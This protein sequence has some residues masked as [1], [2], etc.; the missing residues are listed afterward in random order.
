MSKYFAIH[1]GKLRVD[2]HRTEQES[3]TQY[4]EVGL[5]DVRASDCIRISYDFARDGWVIAQAAYCAKTMPGVVLGPFDWKEVAFVESWAREADP[6]RVRIEDGSVTYCASAETGAVAFSDALPGN[7]D[8][9]VSP[10]S[11]PFTTKKLVGFERI[12]CG[13]DPATPGTENTAL[14]FFN[15]NVVQK[16]E[17]KTVQHLGFT[18]SREDF[19][20]LLA[21]FGHSSCTCNGSLSSGC[22]LCTKD[23]FQRWYGERIN[24]K[25]AGALSR[26]K[27]IHETLACQPQRIID[28]IQRIAC[29][30]FTREEYDQI[31]RVV[32]QGTLLPPGYLRP[33]AGITAAQ[34]ETPVASAQEQ[35]EQE[36]Q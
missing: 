15:P 6:T 22:P 8:I 3:N 25:H 20:A 32:A 18:V 27:R 35:D 5:M 19:D 21:E 12:I 4:I 29:P 33:D 2:L 17:V 11:T 24:A 16:L 13:V 28:P 26:G 30:S 31:T 36:N 7:V 23:Q 14:A 1:D 10:V 34:E 9:V